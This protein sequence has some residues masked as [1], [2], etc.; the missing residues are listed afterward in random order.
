MFLDT[1]LSNPTIF[2]PYKL[3]VSLMNIKKRVT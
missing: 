1:L 3:K 2:K